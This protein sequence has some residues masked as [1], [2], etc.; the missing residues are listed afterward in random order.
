[1]KDS[2][3]QAIIAGFLSIVIFVMILGLLILLVHGKDDRTWNH[4]HCTCGGL[5]QFEEYIGHA[6]STTYM[7]QCDKCG[8][9]HEFHKYYEE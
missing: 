7:Y 3:V 1:M 5:W 9:T 2:D 8:R 4:G 6:Y